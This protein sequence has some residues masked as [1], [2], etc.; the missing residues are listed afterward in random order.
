MEGFD[1]FRLAK[2]LGLRLAQSVK[3]G[4]D[5]FGVLPAGA[6]FQI[7]TFVSVLGKPESLS[8]AL[9]GPALKLSH[10]LKLYHPRLWTLH[11]EDSLNPPTLPHT[12]SHQEHML[13]LAVSKSW[14]SPG[15]ACS[16]EASAETFRQAFTL[17]NPQT[18]KPKTSKHRSPPTKAQS[19]I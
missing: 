15:V 13:D 18:L 14:G 3:A 16:G 17:K 9:L 11:L 1:E 7:S 6:P 5:R 4:T 8:T 19:K 2:G 10:A 12:W